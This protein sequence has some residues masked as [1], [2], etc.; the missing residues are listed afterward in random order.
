MEM[1]LAVGIL[2]FMSISILKVFLMAK[3]LNQKSQDLFQ[4]MLLTKN[5]ISTMD[6]GILPGTEKAQ[7][8][9]EYEIANLTFGK[10]ENVYLLYLDE[11]FKPLPFNTPIQPSYIWRMRFKQQ[12]NI[13]GS[14][15]LYQMDISVT[16]SKPYWAEISHQKPIYSVS[17]KRFLSET[18]E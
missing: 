9:E 13:K 14:E 11:D 6:K 17:M 16:R 7:Q 8:M 2:S 4:S 1:I 10:S 3:T 12:Q 15:G 5:I 18:K